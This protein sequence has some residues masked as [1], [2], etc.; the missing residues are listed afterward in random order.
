MVRAKHSTEYI[1][2]LD[3][4]SQAIRVAVGQVS[5]S[6]SSGTR[7][8]QIVGAVEVPSEGVQKGIVTS[9]EETVSA[10]ANALET[11][12]K[13]SGIPIEHVWVGISGTHII[14]Q[15]SKGVV[16]VSRTDSEITEEDVHR[17]L[18]A[19]KTVATPLNYEILHVLPRSFSVD[20]QTG[21]KDPVGMTGIRLEVDAKIIYGVTAHVKNISKVI[22]RTGV[23][24]DDFV[25]SVIA[26]GEVVLTSR[27]KELGAV[28]VNIGNA[29]TSL[30]VYE[31]GDIVHTAVLPVGSGHITNDL[32][33]GLKTSIDI[34]E[35]V[36]VEYGQCS[37]QT[38][39]KKEM[40]D[41]S[42]LGSRESEMVSRYYIGQIIE[43]RVSEILEKVDAELQKIHRSGL[44]P[45]GVYFVGGGARLGGLTDLAK[46][47]L[48][49]PS[50][51]GYPLNITS[52]TD[53][54]Q[55]VAFASVI[56]LVK[57]GASLADTNT[58][59]PTNFRVVSGKISATVRSI[60]RS[61][62]P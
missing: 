26:A 53:K 3:I 60:F 11:A 10:I 22:Y 15:D 4:G 61:L 2:G 48:Q 20:G 50:A 14:C 49:L 32:A 19:S 24:I 46:E 13:V 55:D 12:E 6:A 43:A 16:A 8:V 42:I 25:L 44:L 36:K 28:V 40:I 30:V 56:G 57:W 59:A 21:I 5:A 23:D 34:A 58:H 31:E 33:L 45:A 52:I 54:I 7:E 17:A 47:Q 27:Q 39:T 35:R 51:L 9:I 37:P 38:I 1:T 62:I 29:T 41:L 18:E